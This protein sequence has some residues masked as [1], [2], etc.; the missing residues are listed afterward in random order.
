M[1]FFFTF[2]QF[3]G[4]YLISLSGNLLKT[5]R[6]YGGPSIMH[7][8]MARLKSIEWHMTPDKILSQK[9]K[10]KRTFISLR[11]HVWI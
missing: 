10:V 5:M 8:V 11:L 4:F 1:V 2:D 6:L 3:F 7:A 9:K